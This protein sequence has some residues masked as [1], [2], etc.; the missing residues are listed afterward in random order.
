MVRSAAWMAAM[1][2]VCGG[3][4][5]HTRPPA[6]SPAR[7]AAVPAAIPAPP[8][9]PPPPARA[10]R[11]AP[12]PTDEE[13]FQ[14]KTLDQLNAERPLTDVFFEYEQNTLTPDGQ[15]ALQADAQWLSRWPSTAVRVD[16]H[17]DERG[18]AEYNLALGDRRANAVKDYLASLG[19]NPSRIEIRSLGKEAPFCRAEGE[20]CWAQNRRGHF[21]IT[22][23]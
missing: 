15:R 20:Q 9:P 11:P 22:R 2:C 12:V 21:V 4:A 1:V 5:C 18:T 19:V 8:A 7:T 16:G 6:T 3:A 17:C 13:L 10:E 14:R 23:K